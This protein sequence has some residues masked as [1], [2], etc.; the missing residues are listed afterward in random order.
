MSS[1]NASRHGKHVNANFANRRQVK[2]PTEKMACMIDTRYMG[3]PIIYFFNF[4]VYGNLADGARYR[5]I[6]FNL[7]VNFL[8]SSICA[9]WQALAF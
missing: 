9:L 4:Q 7:P 2:P 1:I 6:T 8:L 5:G 3:G